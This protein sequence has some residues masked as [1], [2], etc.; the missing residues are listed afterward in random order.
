MHTPMTAEDIIAGTFHHSREG[1]IRKATAGRKSPHKTFFEVKRDL[2][3]LL[4]LFT[5]RVREIFPGSVQL[6]RALSGMDAAGHIPRKVFED[7]GIGG[8]GIRTAAHSPVE[9]P[10]GITE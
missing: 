2:P 5:F 8:H 7:C 3:G 10:G 4:K 1:S 9:R 6:D